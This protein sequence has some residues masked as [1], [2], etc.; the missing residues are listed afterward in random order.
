MTNQIDEFQKPEV[1]LLAVEKEIRQNEENSRQEA[2]ITFIVQ[3]TLMKQLI[4]VV[5]NDGGDDKDEDD[6]LFSGVTYMMM[7]TMKSRIL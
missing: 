2:L 1:S 5:M 7:M 6:I 3:C 4:Q